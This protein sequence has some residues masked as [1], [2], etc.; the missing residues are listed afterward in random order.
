VRSLVIC[1]V[2]VI[3]GNAH[4]E[5]RGTL[6]L[7][8]TLRTYDHS[9]GESEDNAGFGPGLGVQLLRAHPDY[10]HGLFVAWHTYREDGSSGDAYSRF[11]VFQLHYFIER[12]FSAGALGAGIG[13]DQARASN[14]ST[15]GAY[16]YS[17][18]DTMIAL[19][20]QLAIDVITFD[21]GDKLGFVTGLGVFPLLDV[22]P[23]LTNGEVDVGWRGI[24]ASA[25]VFWQ[26]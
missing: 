18:R 12:R 5:I 10:A 19:D 7:H 9:F 14:Y 1:V 22:L 21:R 24:T 11:H 2:L 4:A 17:D 8:G 16:S 20:V 13:L 15:D 26:H 6:S 23:L 25:G 3:S